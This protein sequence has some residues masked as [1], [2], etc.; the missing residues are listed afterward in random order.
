MSGNGTGRPMGPVA[1][2]G[3]GHHHQG[4][5]AT[6]PK[7]KNAR[8]TLKRLGKYLKP[9]KAALGL[10]LMMVALSAAFN[11]TGPFLIGRA[12]DDYIIPGDIRG[13]IGISVLMLVIYILG[14]L[15][16]WLQNHIMVGLAQE[17]VLEIRKDLFKK[18]QVLP[19]SFFDSRPHGDL[20]SRLTNDV[21]NISNTL[22]TSVT[23][24]FSSVFTFTGTLAMM[25]YLSPLLTLFTMLIVPVMLFCTGMVA[26][27]T[28]LLFV[29]QQKELGHLNG[30]IEETIS[31]QKVV[32]LFSRE[33]DNI[34]EF[35]KC[36][37]RLKAVS[38]RAQIFSGI[39]P[40]LMNLLNNIGFAIVAGVG[41]YL[42]VRNI[43]TVGVIA[44]FLNYSR[45]FSRPLN[46]MANQF[47]MIQVA[48]AGAERVF[49]VMDEEPEPADEP[50][51]VVLNEVAGAVKFQDV[52]FG[53]RK[54]SPV[55]KNINLD[56]RPG[57]TIA[58][59]GPT[60]AGKTTIVN[61]LCRFYDVDRGK[62]TIDGRDIRQIQR[63]SLRSALGIV[64][65]NTFLFSESVR[66]NI[67]YG[68]LD[69][70]D[71]EV[72]RAAR[73]A[74]AD[75]FIR[76]L[77]QGYDTI[78]TENGSNLSQGQRQLLAIARAILADPAILVLDE[79]TSN[80]DTRTEYYLRQAM[81][82]LMKGRTSFVIA[83]RLSTVRNADLILV[84]NGGEIV[85]RGTHEELLKQKGFYYHLY[86]SQFKRRVS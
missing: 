19:L 84:V 27:R 34:L 24:F 20:M 3:R 14:A 78:L 35:E 25:L 10:V 82:T 58:L 50:D 41:G 48:L 60:G 49:E 6:A 28:R 12:I 8:E 54:D 17:T 40:P 37:Q 77:P 16:T 57:Q 32:K 55:V 67:R 53:Y 75:H 80:V 65:Q 51:A 81:L 66:N 4:R 29:D 68:R 79:A 11:L 22:S 39:M 63:N 70:T 15:S 42:A 30:F 1:G 26:R 76:R 5:F 72:E 31:G 7:V 23:Q 85:E 69:A 44:S 18:L 86:S 9:K 2:F 36:N 59:V 73:L 33:E 83:H 71:E 43:I 52:F 56:V 74:N 61:L 64:L 13:L 46:E 38:V 21:E 47:N 62:I 45:Q